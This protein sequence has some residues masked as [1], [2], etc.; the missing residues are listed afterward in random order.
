VPNLRDHGVSATSDHNSVGW[1]Y[2]YHLDTLGAWDYAVND[3]DNK[4]GG[5]MSKDKVGILG[6]SMGGFVTS[7]AFGFEPDVP[8]AWVDS[9]VFEPR[10]VLDFSMAASKVGFLGAPAWYFAKTAAGVDLTLHTPAKT[11]P[12][13]ATKKRPIAI[14]QGQKD[15]VVPPFQS[16]G[17][18]KLVKSL[19]HLYEVK[20]F[21]KPTPDCTKLG[22]CDMHIWKPDVYRKKLCDF[23]THV[24]GLKVEHCGIDDLPKYDEQEGSKVKKDRRMTSAGRAPKSQEQVIV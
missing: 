8:G 3:P 10:E 15:M 7:T 13:H 22:H 6:F 9:G 23:W 17:L 18:H 4:L 14:A 1:G 16:E 20:E 19:P 24:F 2:D 12:T 21:Y 5:A 11:L